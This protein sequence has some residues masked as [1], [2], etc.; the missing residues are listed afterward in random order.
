M[1]RQDSTYYV[2]ATG[3]GI[4]VWSSPDMKSWTRLAPVFDSAPAWAGDVVPRFRNRE[5]APDISLHHGTYYLYYAVSA[6][7][8]NTSAI[9]VATSR[10]HDPHDPAFKW[11]DHSIVVESVPG[12]DLWNAID[13]NSSWT[14]MGRRG[15]RS[16]RS[17]RASSW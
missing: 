4:A 16:A 2:F 12:R 6:L 10:T 15:S 8:K 9:G 3:R 17:G 14:P 1:I 11:V 13:P 5:W 7:G